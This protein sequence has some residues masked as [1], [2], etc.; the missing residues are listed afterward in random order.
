MRL[1][2]GTHPEAPPGESAASPRPNTPNQAQRAVGHVT[3][4]VT[5]VT[6]HAAA[7]AQPSSESPPPS[8]IMIAASR[9][10]ERSDAERTRIQSIVDG[11]NIPKGK[12]MEQSPNSLDHIR[13]VVDAI[14]WALMS[15]GGPGNAH[16]TLQSRLNGARYALT[17]LREDEHRPA[18]T[19]S[20]ILRDAERYLWA[21]TGTKG[22]SGYVLY[23]LLKIAGLSTQHAIGWN[24]MKVNPN[25]EMSARGGYTWFHLG[26]LDFKRFDEGNGE[27][28][29]QPTPLTYEEVILFEGDAARIQELEQS[30]PILPH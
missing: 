29:I 5:E 30:Q 4:P 23:D 22:A 9:Y 1:A 2:E 26:R 18:N 14:N 7:P 16:A 8:P 10:R 13:K 28:A 19:E 20:L 3:I 24:P 27:K 17:L 21:R 15:Q 25:R 11:E 12:L 6:G